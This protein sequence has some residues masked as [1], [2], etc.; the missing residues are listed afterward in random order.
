MPRLIHGFDYNAYVKYEEQLNGWKKQT[1][2]SIQ[3]SICLPN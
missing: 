3:K 1:Q 2:E